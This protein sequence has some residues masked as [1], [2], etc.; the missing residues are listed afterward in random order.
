[1]EKEEEGVYHNFSELLLEG[2]L[3]HGVK[4]S[5]SS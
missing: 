4:V 2:D 5:L 1:M 3:V